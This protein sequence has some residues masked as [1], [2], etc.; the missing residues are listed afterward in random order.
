M[1]LTGEEHDDPPGA[2]GFFGVETANGIDIGCGA[3]D[4]FAGG[5]AIMVGEGEALDMVVKVIAQADGGSFGGRG[6]PTAAE[7]GEG[8]LSQGQEHKAEG[9]PGQLLHLAGFA[10]H[11]VGVIAQ[12]VEEAGMENGGETDADHRGDDEG[13]VA[14]EHAPQTEQSVV[15]CRLLEVEIGLAWK[16]LVS[17]EP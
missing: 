11:I 6:G 13:L 15:G 9:D 1:K 17:H 7:E 2:N 8:A 5:G 4:Q 3:L 14:G 10:E 16:Y 12:E